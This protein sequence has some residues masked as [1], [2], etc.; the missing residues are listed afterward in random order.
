[1][2]LCQ[3]GLG[4][5]MFLFSDMGP[6]TTIGLAPNQACTAG[7]LTQLDNA[8]RYYGA[9]IGFYLGPPGPGG[10]APP[11]QLAGTGVSV[12]LSNMPSGGARL[13]VLVAGV[14]YCADVLST[15]TTIPWTHFRYQCYASPPG[16]ALGAAP[17]TPF[18]TVNI[19][20]DPQA[21]V[22]FDFCVEKLSVTTM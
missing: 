21:E 7:T 8:S 15:S 18:I 19:L 10:T 12:Q 2:E 16:V 14:T 22:L 4:G 5:C 11:V 6:Q 9:G 17:S 13:Q 3:V 1:M 20:S